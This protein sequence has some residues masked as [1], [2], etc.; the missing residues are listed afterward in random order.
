[1]DIRYSTNPNDVK[2][3]DTARTR[4]EYLIDSLFKKGKIVLVYSHV[5]RMITGSACPRE[6]RIALAAGRELGVEFF[7]QRREMVVLNIGSKGIVNA[8]GSSYKLGKHDAIY[9]GMGTREVSFEGVDA[10]F[11][12]LSCPAHMAYPTTVVSLERAV[13]VHL[14][15]KKDANE[16]TINKYLDPSIVKTCQ[17]AMGMT[18]LD[19][20]CVW[21]TMPSHTHERR[22]E[23][24]MYMDLPEDGFVVHLMGEPHETRHLIVRNEQA[25]ISPSW[26]IHSG[27]GT[28]NYAFVW[29]M[30][31]E[32][33]TYDDMDLIG[34]KDFL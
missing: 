22:M 29:G 27:V 14:G 28:I 23:V 12:I 16:R 33:Q 26:S 3:Y 1:M 34:M 10:K 18:Q 11:Y 32:N 9:I 7:L 4:K 17:L 8:D 24:Y 2:L 15:S 13:K 25:V 19:E 5:D 6:G 21:N 31:G 30:C 20:G